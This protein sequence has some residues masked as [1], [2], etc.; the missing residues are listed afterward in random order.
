MK[1]CKKFHL[2]I[3]SLDKYKPNNYYIQSLLGIFPHFGEVQ[4]NAFYFI[5]F[6]VTLLKTH[7]T[8]L[9]TTCQG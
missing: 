9:S 3:C 1:A 4:F 6:Y 2:K 8:I 7:A 5:T